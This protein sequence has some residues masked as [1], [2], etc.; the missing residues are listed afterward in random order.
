MGERP[1]EVGGWGEQMVGGIWVGGVNIPDGEL[2]AR[3]CSA[4]GERFG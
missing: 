3:E 2:S 4:D 1:G